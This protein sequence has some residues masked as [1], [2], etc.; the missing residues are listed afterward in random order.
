MDQDYSNLLQKIIEVLEQRLGGKKDSKSDSAD[1]KQQKTVEE[2]VK[3]L[4]EINK[5]NKKYK[6]S[7][8]EKIKST[9]DASEAIDDMADAANDGADGISK[10]TV[11]FKVFKASLIAFATATFWQA[12]DQMKR[13]V[14]L[15]RAGLGS[16]LRSYGLMESSTSALT[17]M[18]GN[19]GLPAAELQT[20]LTDFS[21]GVA[22]IGITKFNSVINQTK[23]S[24]M[25]FGM[26]LNEGVRA[27][28]DFIDQ[29]RVW[30][31]Q[32]QIS[33]TQ[34][35]AIVKRNLKNTSDFANL[36]GISRKEMEARMRTEE[37]DAAIKMFSQTQLRGE[38]LYQ[39]ALKANPALAQIISEA[40]Y[41]KQMTGNVY[42]TEKTAMYQSSQFGREM[43]TSINDLLNNKDNMSSAEITQAILRLSSNTASAAEREEM[44]RQH[45]YAGLSTEMLSLAYTTNEAAAAMAGNAEAVKKQMVLTDLASRAQKQADAMRQKMLSMGVPEELIDISGIYNEAYLELIAHS[46]LHADKILI[47]GIKLDD[48]TNKL[49]S[50]FDVI[51]DTFGN[52]VAEAFGGSEELNKAVDFFAKMMRELAAFVKAN[53]DDIVTALTF[54]F[55][56]IGATLRGILAIV[57]GLSQGVRMIYNLFTMDFGEA[58][59][60][61]KGLF[62]TIK[63]NA[64]AI[65]LGAVAMFAALIAAFGLIKAKAVAFSTIGGL[66]GSGGA[67]RGGGLGAG[68]ARA[69][70]GIGGSIASIGQ[71]I[72]AGLGG[73]LSGTLK[74]LASGL[75]AL[76]NPKVLLGIVALG[77]MA[78]VVYLS[79]KA[80]KEFEGVNWGNVWEGMKVMGVMAAGAVVLGL[81]AKFMILGAVGL[82]ALGAAAVVFAFAANLAAPAIESMAV[83]I[84]AMFKQLSEVDPSKMMLIGPALVGLAAGLAALSAA[85]LATTVMDF[86]NKLLGGESPVEKLVKIGHAAE[87]INL[88]ADSLKSLDFSELKGLETLDAGAISDNL[89]MVATGLERVRDSAPRERILPAILGSVQTA[90]GFNRKP[91]PNLQEQKEAEDL[92]NTMQ[93]RVSLTEEEIVKVRKILEKTLENNTKNLELMERLTK[94]V[95]AKSGY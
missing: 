86:F 39:D 43:M 88:L 64:G 62:T 16:T 26:T 71:G 22:A 10:T 47:A 56:L 75:S 17:A 59:D 29:N 41:A 78:G 33:D 6:E 24:F 94:R 74:G 40:A 77:G 92:N 63:D 60:M 23:H 70:A 72:G 55:D 1:K 66:L 76:G 30:M 2:N 79:A 15:E 57:K 52:V 19:I 83:S 36:L 69:G 87:S 81:V 53:K 73:L 18:V 46:E 31:V 44:M 32:Q 28:A 50:S 27:T 54:I 80:F 11:A 21:Q 61:M 4:I 8:D 20:I 85:G 49:S 3:R 58:W 35:A 7:L 34:A 45:T 51:M 67:T 91:E 48:M 95:G 93:A 90:L 82:L 14:A 12:H 38:Q 89:N 13:A 65:T 68:G 25:S 5:T 42:G 37:T 9:K 84:P